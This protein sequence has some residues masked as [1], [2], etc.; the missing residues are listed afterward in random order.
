MLIVP[1][2]CFLRDHNG[3]KAY[4]LLS[5]CNPYHQLS[6]FNATYHP[7]TFQASL[8]N[9][10]LVFLP[11]ITT[12]QPQLLDAAV[13]KNFK[14]KHRKMLVRYVVSRTDEVKTASKI[15]EDV[16]VLKTITWLQTTRKIVSTETIKQCFK[17]CGFDVEDMS[18]INE[19]IDTEFHKLFA[20]ISS[21][22]TFDEY[23]G[24]DAVTITSEPAVDSTHVDWRQCR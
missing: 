1:R 22:T 9:V 3:D 17:K 19:E 14:H 16:H 18:I 13:I 5:L 20:Q 21:E 2:F 8:T 11:K 10:Q 24:F 7:E 6:T 12:S 23:I 15:I 4:K